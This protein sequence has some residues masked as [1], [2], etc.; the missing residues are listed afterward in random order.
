MNV[1]TAASVS[2]FEK[3]RTLFKEYAQSLP[4]DLSYQDFEKE[5]DTLNT[6]YN[7]PDGALLLFILPDNNAAGCVGVRKF[8]EGIAELK[9]LYVK[10]D[11]RNLKI[12]KT[13]LETAIAIA[14]HLNYA[15]MRLDSVPGQSKAQ[16]LYKQ[17]GFYEIPP[18]RYSPVEGT[19]FF[20][21]IL[22]G[23]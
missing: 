5:L 2:D 13:L 12:G 20:E 3:A 4:F 8:S 16:E 1:I 9:R 22:A 7:K 23:Q 11:H 21:K 18:Y 19:I 15:Y 17:F 6:Q 14:R 10:P